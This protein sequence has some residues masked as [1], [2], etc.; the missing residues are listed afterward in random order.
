MMTSLLSVRASAIKLSEERLRQARNRGFPAK[1]NRYSTQS[2]FFFEENS[3]EYKS[4]VTPRTNW[5]SGLAIKASSL[6]GSA[7]DR[8]LMSCP[9]S[10]EVY[11]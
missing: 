10:L 8:L 3:C 4:V 1:G 9:Q 11:G 2:L 7:A 5:Q 6:T